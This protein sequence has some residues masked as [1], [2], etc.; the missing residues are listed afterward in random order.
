M[1]FL[2]TYFRDNIVAGVY[3][4]ASKDGS[5]FE[6]VNGGNSIMTPP[7]WKNQDLTRDPSIIYRNGLFR[8]VWTSHW[9]GKVFGYVESKYLLHRSELLM[10]LEFYD[11]RK[12]S[13]GELVDE[14]R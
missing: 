8:M 4:A 5:R 2:F 10:D 11:E 3:L 1:F 14:M 7:Q 9:T 13:I 6:T 12:A